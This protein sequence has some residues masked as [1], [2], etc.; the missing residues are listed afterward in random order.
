MLSHR[1]S[2]VMEISCL[3]AWLM[4]LLLLILR[5]VIEII[6]L[7]HDF[8]KMPEHEL[9]LQLW[10]KVHTAVTACVLVGVLP[11]L[12]YGQER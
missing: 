5:L 1:P 2:P 12:I 9:C 3:V 7:C 4:A 6:E 11:I 10:G 8:L